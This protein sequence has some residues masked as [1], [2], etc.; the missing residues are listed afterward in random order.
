MLTLASQG[1]A[2]AGVGV[3]VVHFAAA[4]L[5]SPNIFWKKYCEE[6]VTQPTDSSFLQAPACAGYTQIDWSVFGFFF[7]GSLLL[8]VCL[9]GISCIDFL[10]VELDRK[11]NEA[12]GL[13]VTTKGVELLASPRQSPTSSVTSKSLSRSP[14]QTRLLEETPC[15]CVH[16]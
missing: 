6:T 7:L 13:N 10:K 11:S 14:S 3:S 12:Q 5:Q 15:Q 8:L 2:I 4:W 16:P 1:Q 9:V